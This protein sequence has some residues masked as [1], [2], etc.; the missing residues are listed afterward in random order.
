MIEHRFQ[1]KKKPKKKET[2]ALNVTIKKKKLKNKK[3]GDRKECVKWKTQT[4]AT[5]S[6]ALSFARNGNKTK[7]CK[8]KS[9]EMP[10]QNPEAK[11]YFNKQS[12]ASEMTVEHY[13]QQKHRKNNNNN[14]WIFFLLPRMKRDF[15]WLFQQE[16][17]KG[18]HKYGLAL[19]FFFFFFFL[20][21]W[22]QVKFGFII[23]M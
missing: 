12:N 6:L 23:G 17:L 7:T 2:I 13:L 18:L 4:V 9:K 1:T 5:D 21:D 11:I 14:N 15:C 20:F 16:I 19:L 10:L 22:N 3:K 8:K